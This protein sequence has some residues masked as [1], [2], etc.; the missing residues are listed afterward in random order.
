MASEPSIEFHS[1]AE[2]WD[3]YSN[4][5]M[6][7]E[8]VNL[9]G[10]GTETISLNN[11][12]GS[13]KSILVSALS[14]K[15]DQNLFIILDDE[16]SADS[17]YNDV[18][19][20]SNS[21]NVQIFP[22][23]YLLRF[24]T[25][26]VSA[27]NVQRRFNTIN[28]V[29]KYNRQIVITYPEAIIE[30]CLDYSKL[31]KAAINLCVG[32]SVDL[33]FLREVLFDFRFDVVD[34]VNQPG[35][36]SIRGGIVDIFTFGNANPFRLE[37]FDDEIESIRIFDPVSQL[38]L[39]N[40]TSLNIYPNVLDTSNKE[41]T[42]TNVLDV[43][44]KDTL[45]I[46]LN[47]EH[48]VEGL[49]FH[50]EKVESFGIKNELNFDELGINVIVPSI[51]TF[52]KYK[53]I[54]FNN[55]GD[56]SLDFCSEE[57]PVFNKSFDLLDR[58]IVNYTSLGYRVFICSEN[59]LQLNRLWSI[60]R[61]QGKKLS[62]DSVLILLHEGF[63]DHNNK[64]VIYPDHQ[65]FNRAVKGS[66]SGRVSTDTA[67]FL[68]E[69]NDL[70]PG[71]YVTHL[72]HGIGKYSGLE[73]LEVNGKSQEM[74]R[75]IYADNDVLYVSIQSLHKIS[76]YA[77]KDNTQPK[78]HK[79]GS[80]VWTN[81]KNRTKAK[82]KDIAD[83]LIKLYATRKAKK[84]FAFSPDNY[85]QLELEASFPH[86][87]TI[88]QAKAII[89]VKADMESSTP[90]DRLICGDVGFGKTEIAIRAA[91][92][93][94]CDDKQV[95]VL[96]PTTI[97]ASQHY[98]SFRERLDQFGVNIEF[99]NRFISTKKKNEIIE[100]IKKGSV[101]IIIGTH[102]IVSKQFIYKDLGL[103]VID[104]EQKFG[105]G[106]KE[107][108]RQLRAEVDTLALT[109]TPIPRTLQFSLMGARDLSIL[110]TPP[111]DRLPV[112]TEVLYFSTDKIREAIEYEKS[113]DGQVFFVHNR[114]TDI[115]E[116]ELLVKK[117]CP[118]VSVAV[119]HGQL[120]AHTLENVMKRFMDK[121]IDVLVS[122]NI[123]ESGLN[124]PNAN[125]IIIHNA[126]MYGLSDLHQLR[127]RVGRSQRRAF[128]FLITPN[129]STL[130]NDAR[131]RL[132][133]IQE[134]TN[135]GSGFQIAMRDLDIRG[136][137]N[138]LG[139]EQ[140]G[141]ISDIGYDTYHKI[142]DEAIKELRIEKYQEL[143]PKNAETLYNIVSTCQ[144]E[145]EEEMLIP[146]TYVKSTEERMRIYSKMSSLQTKKELD[147]Y[148]LEVEDRFGKLPVQIL[149]IVDGIRLQWVAKRFGI[150]KLVINK[151]KLKA[152]FVSKDH[153]H[154]YDTQL[155]GQFI[156]IVNSEKAIS[157]K[158]SADQLIVTKEG[159]KDVNAAIL[160]FER[161]LLQIE[162]STLSSHQNH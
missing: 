135:L 158:Q 125:T 86:E 22:H 69:L 30:G 100:G 23:S 74:V 123:I 95:V 99:V 37:L 112:H 50:A 11:C 5:S 144:L 54:Y 41:F 140:S 128:C 111:V 42:I 25:I 24:D 157:L 18:I 4:S 114:V 66:L 57:A 38:S 107:K 94:V 63:I 122:T 109:A 48:L 102:S 47:N 59:Q 33:D 80:E 134:F 103:I 156:S 132:K 35:Q 10:K 105:V 143:F 113:R 141:F 40:I 76:K 2:F 145:T 71:D 21:E 101:Q 12:S 79:L 92:K 58:S 153:V 7:N 149:N 110:S 131:R 6:V 56:Q 62:Y 138:I 97:L 124:V 67:K 146:D 49:Q 84:G 55:S 29:S 64:I 19:N 126:H 98:L 139:A 108:L 120:E 75:L 121:E 78:I 117:L 52:Q 160:F 96:V 88:D 118:I 152:Y 147:D 45:L 87:D 46:I 133:T 155:F 89:E 116:I 53:R 137:G 3:V 129:F 31:N 15:V 68:K 72:D 61:D 32:Q 142:L 39:R 65:I 104:E 44:H 1:S 151:D 119:A 51:S 36:F 150:S 91:F 27:D 17:F 70:K 136:A 161:I 9:L 20:F 13:Y 162:D 106:V 83:D 85:F 28:N 90:M 26:E 148:L 60:F 73:K 14:S 43:I 34:F 93:A 130:T 81:L 8:L 154:F 77:G 127:G 16:A 159:I 82:I 115:V